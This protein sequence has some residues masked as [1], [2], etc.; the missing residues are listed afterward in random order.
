MKET[1]RCLPSEFGA[2]RIFYTRD[3]LTLAKEGHV[4]QPLHKPAGDNIGQRRLPWRS[5][6]HLRPPRP[7]LVPPTPTTSPFAGPPTPPWPLGLPRPDPASGSATA[8]VAAHTH[9]ITPKA[10]RERKAGWESGI[11][12]PLQDPRR[13]F[14]LC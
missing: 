4:R 3:N 9:P 12:G 2:T 7:V 5:K 14:V 11:V 13:H 10:W 6:A 1:D 8:C